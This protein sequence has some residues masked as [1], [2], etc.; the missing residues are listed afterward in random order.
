MLVTERYEKNSNASYQKVYSP[1]MTVF[2]KK[3]KNKSIMIIPQREKL[4]LDNW[5]KGF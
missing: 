2:R 4:F 1:H 3:E 5:L